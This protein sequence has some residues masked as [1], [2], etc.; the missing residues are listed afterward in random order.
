MSLLDFR[1]ASILGNCL[2]LRF[3]IVLHHGSVSFC[4]CQSKLKL[5]NYLTLPCCWLY[6]DSKD[7]SHAPMSIN[8]SRES[9]GNDFPA[10]FRQKPYR[11]EECVCV[12]VCLYTWCVDVLHCRV[13]IFR[14]TPVCIG[15]RENPAHEVLDVNDL[16]PTGTDV[17]CILQVAFFLLL[18]ACS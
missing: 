13:Y 11:K 15:A 9:C 12:C 8:K 10:N 14:I 7:F 4:F 18:L 17:C 16:A 2:R 3:F 1:E 6:R 5:H